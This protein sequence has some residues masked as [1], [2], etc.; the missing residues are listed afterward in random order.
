MSEESYKAIPTFG[1]KAAQWATFMYKLK[2]YLNAKDLADHIEHPVS[3]TLT[4]PPVGAWTTSAQTA[5]LEKL[6]KWQKD[7]R[8]VIS[9]IAE[10]VG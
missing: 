4:N 5:Q 9:M 6:D 10:Q 1:A 3:I 8:R 2:M 7:D